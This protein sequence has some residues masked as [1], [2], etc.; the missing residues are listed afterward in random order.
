MSVSND[1]VKI[2]L[3]GFYFQGNTGDD[4]LME[5]IVKASSRHGEVKVTSTETFDPGLLD[6]CQLLIIGAGSHTRQEV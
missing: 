2:L 5:S 3:C 4:L 6:W 1:G